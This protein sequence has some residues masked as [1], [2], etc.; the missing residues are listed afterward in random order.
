MR[1]CLRGPLEELP[2][3]SGHPGPL[4]AQADREH[5][6]G[7]VLEGARAQEQHSPAELFAR[8]LREPP[9]P[10]TVPPGRHTHI[11][12]RQRWPAWTGR[13]ERI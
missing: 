3:E 9:L 1:D 12:T 4:T 13:A 5:V 7:P 2:H 10:R 6:G 11:R 8:Q